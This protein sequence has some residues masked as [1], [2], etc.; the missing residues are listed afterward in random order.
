MVLTRL[1]MVIAFLPTALAAGFALKHAQAAHPASLPGPIVFTQLELAQP[2]AAGSEPRARLV[3]LNMDGALRVLTSGFLAARDP[4]V[5]FD[6]ERILFAGKRTANEYWQIY[7]MRADGTAIRRVTS[8]TMDCREPIY[9]SRL[10]VISSDE[11]WY[12]IT[13]VG[14]T[15]GGIA[16]LF[17]AR[18]DGTAVRQ[19]TFNPYGAADPAMLPDGRILFSGRQSHRLEPGPK[20]R[21]ALFGLNLDGTDYAAFAADEGAPWKQMPAVTAGG[22]AVFVENDKPLW[23]GGGWL[24]AVTL[25][26][27]LHS[28]RRLTQPGEALYHSP[29]PLPSNEILVSRRPADGSGT[30]G[31]YRFDPATGGSGLVHDD[32]GYHD[33]QA[34]LIAPRAEPDG[35]SSVVNEEIPT[36]LLYCLNVYTT[37]FRN[38]DWLPAGSVKRLRVVEGVPRAGSGTPPPARRMLGEI[39]VEQDGSF[40]IRVPANIPIK[41][42]LLDERGISLRS[43]SW[44][45]VKNNEPRGCIGCH[46]DGELTPEDRVPAAVT[47]PPISLTLPPERRR[48]VTYDRDVRPIFEQR[49]ATPACHSGSVPPRLSDRGQARV[50]AAGA[51]RTSPLVW[52]LFGRK[53]TRPWDGPQ[54]TAEAVERMPPKE[55]IPLTDDEL[56]TII[57]WIDLGAE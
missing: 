20:D 37:D 14:S 56:R 30:H 12:Q 46:E 15:P 26:R 2:H 16:N 35:R 24:A 19:I 8:E 40:N 41:L 13:F 43:C 22:L 57:E 31:I 33:I 38:P 11:P 54:L 23:D 49:C 5:S 7:E 28:H 4:D 44:I 34:K 55:A 45:W 10:Y 36:G 29:S 9:Q 32:T 52:H 17:S 53:T 21:T 1:R 50:Y 27:N 39:D 25:R 18:L 6:G 48:T 51:A 42:Q 47:R 3:R